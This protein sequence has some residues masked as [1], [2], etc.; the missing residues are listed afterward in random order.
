MKRL[1]QMALEIYLMNSC[2]ARSS[3]SY[4]IGLHNCDFDFYLA[5][6]NVHYSKQRFNNQYEELISSTEGLN[7]DNLIVNIADR[8]LREKRQSSSHCLNRT[9]D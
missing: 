3:R 7:V 5:S 6:V 1:T 4:S 8:A 2:I 9:Y